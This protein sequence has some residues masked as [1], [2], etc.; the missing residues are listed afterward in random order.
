MKNNEGKLTESSEVNR[1]ASKGSSQS[2]K[3]VAPQEEHTKTHHNS[4]TQDKR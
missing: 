3:E 1:H 4:I 2:S